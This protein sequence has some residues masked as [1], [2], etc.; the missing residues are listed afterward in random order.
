MRGF[1]VWHSVI[2]KQRTGQRVLVNTKDSS[3]LKLAS[4]MW[5]KNIMKMIYPC[6]N[7]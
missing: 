2:A 1:S 6:I 7:E 4:Y 5:I 3:M